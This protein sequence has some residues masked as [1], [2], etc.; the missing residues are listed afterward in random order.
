MSLPATTQSN[1]SCWDGLRHD[2]RREVLNLASPSPCAGKSHTPMY[3]KR[4]P[5]AWA[6]NA[7]LSRSKAVR[8]ARTPPHPPVVCLPSTKSKRLQMTSFVARRRDRSLITLNM[9]LRLYISVWRIV[10]FWRPNSDFCCAWC[11]DGTRSLCMF[12][13]GRVLIYYHALVSQGA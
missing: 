6:M 9:A 7:S 10:L 2:S 3:E 1:P 4:A 13:G 8:L 12:P 11:V 5:H